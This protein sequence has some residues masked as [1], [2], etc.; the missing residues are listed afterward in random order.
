[1]NKH[2]KH[3]SFSFVIHHLS[4]YLLLLCLPLQLGRHFWFDFSYVRGIRI[5]YLSPTLYLTDILVA[6]VIGFWGLELVQQRM[7]NGKSKKEKRKDLSSRPTMPAG[8]QEWRDLPRLSNPLRYMRLPTLEDPHLAG[9]RAST[10]LG[11][12][13]TVFILINIFSSISPWLTLYKWIKV[14]ELGLL[15]F[16]V[17]HNSQ[18]AIRNSFFAIT[19]IYSFL[20][21]FSQFIHSGSLGGVLWWLG[22]RTFSTSTPGIA[23][24]SFGGHQFLRPYATFSHPNVMAGYS[25]VVIMLLIVQAKKIKLS[26]DRWLVLI[27]TI[28]GIGSII[29]SASRS[30]WIVGCVTLVTVLFHRHFFKRPRF[31]VLFP[32]TLTIGLFFILQYILQFDETVQ[33]RHIL[34]TLAWKSFL[35]YPFFGTG[36]GT[37]ISSIPEFTP[38]FSNSILQP[39]H[40]SMLLILA[41]LGLV[42]L[43]ITTVMA[44]AAIKRAHTMHWVYS[45]IL[46]Q[47]VSLS[48]VDHYFFTLQQTQLLLAIVVG[49]IYAKRS[50][51]FKTQNSK[52]QRE[53][54]NFT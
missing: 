50:S 23:L 16:Y 14:L 28:C 26:L 29:L 45:L 47:I 6:L 31:G 41:E 22:E 46:I 13:I 36:L 9:G 48:M 39:V 15:A 10:M 40:N 4:F 21:A 43:S 3:S 12:T 27:G 35:K 54:L 52:L 24:V 38:V 18:F 53:I 42:G 8:R 34:N 17:S 32:F 5:D 49:M 51:K 25:L 33:T 1:M 30:V 37:F 44:I 7:E 19:L 11:M 2:I 20:I